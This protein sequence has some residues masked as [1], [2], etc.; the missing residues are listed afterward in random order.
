MPHDFQGHPLMLLPLA[1][2]GL[3]AVLVP[4]STEFETAS[5]GTEMRQAVYADCQAQARAPGATA[6][7]SGT[8]PRT[9]SP[10]WLQQRQTEFMRCLHAGLPGQ[11]LSASR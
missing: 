8:T 1:L 4:P 10:A 6:P 2:A 7:H 9:Q 11:V 3:V 5:A